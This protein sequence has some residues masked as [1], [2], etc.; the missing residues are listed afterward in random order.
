[1]QCNDPMS[2]GNGV[3][4]G[5]SLSRDVSSRSLPKT[6]VAGGWHSFQLLLNARFEMTFSVS[7][8]NTQLN[9]LSRSSELS[10]AFKKS[11]HF[12]NV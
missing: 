5:G 12:N 10:F 1:M 9:R 11:L 2:A 6:G 4:A 7:S 3:G 8:Q